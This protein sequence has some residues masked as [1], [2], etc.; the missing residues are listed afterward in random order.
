MLKAGPE[1]VGME[2][3]HEH[4]PLCYDAYSDETNPGVLAFRS[5]QR[6][7]LLAALGRRHV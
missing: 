2:T 3:K 6:L 4:L 5:W 1:I 7:R